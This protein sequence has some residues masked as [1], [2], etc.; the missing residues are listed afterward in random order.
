MF[1]KLFKMYFWYV[2]RIDELQLI[3]IWRR[4]RNALS[5][6][7]GT[8]GIQGFMSLF[9]LRL[10]NFFMFIGLAF[11]IQTSEALASTGMVRVNS[12]V[13]VSPYAYFRLGDIIQIKLLQRDYLL[14][15][16]SRIYWVKLEVQ[17]RF[18]SFFAVAWELLL[19]LI[20]RWPRPYEQ[21][22]AGN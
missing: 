15:T 17:S 11:D 4:A 18:I 6:R 12:F 9:Q 21:L 19:F 13:K 3:R 10:S 2:T 1:F 16:F 22:R 7:F 8:P 14:K 20:L 5:G